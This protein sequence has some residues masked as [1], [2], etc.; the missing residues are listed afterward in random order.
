MTADN[1]SRKANYLQIRD[2]FLLAEFCILRD[3]GVAEISNISAMTAYFS[4]GNKD[5][6]RILPPF[7]TG[8]IVK[9]G[10]EIVIQNKVVS[11]C[12]VEFNSECRGWHYGW[13]GSRFKTSVNHVLA[14]HILLPSKPKGQSL[15]YFG[16]NLA[17]TFNSPSFSVVSLRRKGQN[18]FPDGDKEGKGLL[19]L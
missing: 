5:K 4:Q 10:P 9:I 11:S 12:L 18:I 6:S 1:P 19:C 3:D 14:V 16:L 15:N 8:K 2:I 17:A 7:F 13:T